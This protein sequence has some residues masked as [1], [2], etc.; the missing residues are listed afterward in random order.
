M[1]YDTEHP[2]CFRTLMMYEGVG[3]IPPFC[4]RDSQ[5]TFSAQRR[6]FV[7][8][9][10]NTSWCVSFQGSNH[11]TI[12]SRVSICKGRV[13][14]SR[15]AEFDQSIETI[16]SLFLQYAAYY[17]MAKYLP[18]VIPWTSLVGLGLSQTNL[19]SV[20]QFYLFCFMTMDARLALQVTAYI[21]FTE[22]QF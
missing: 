16:L 11:Q 4:Y 3:T 14:S 20:V 13:G 15:G 19:R 1:H 22:G 8:W 5:G 2:D 10:D 17:Q 18:T 21:L 7:S 9:Y 6:Y 12:H